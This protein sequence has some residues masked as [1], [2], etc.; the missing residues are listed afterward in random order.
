MVK[1]TTNVQYCGFSQSANH[2]SARLLDD[3]IDMK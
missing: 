2:E 3:N 1:T